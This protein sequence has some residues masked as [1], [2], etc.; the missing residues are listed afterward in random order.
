MSLIHIRMALGVAALLATGAAAAQVYKWVDA[1]GRTHYSENK[2]NA[3]KA[4]TDEL[5]IK[6]Q[7][8][9]A[10]SAEASARHW[11]EQERV[12]R[13]RHAEEQNREAKRLTAEAGRRPKSLSG[14]REDGS[15]QSRCNLARDVLNGTVK[16]SNGAPIDKYDREIA[17]KDV[18]T[19]CR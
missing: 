1:E 10:E 9:T 13:Q 8:T 11:S 19:Y 17:E 4:K 2:A 18:G 12:L 6:P 15:A 5:K 3:G 7:P 16:H 14:G